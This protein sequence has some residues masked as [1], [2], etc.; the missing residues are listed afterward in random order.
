MAITAFVSLSR[1]SDVSLRH[2]LENKRLLIELLYTLLAKKEEGGLRDF[3]SYTILCTPLSYLTNK[4]D[5]T[6]INKGINTIITHFSKKF[7]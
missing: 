4:A 6:R 1:P 5:K 7:Y 2:W 3:C